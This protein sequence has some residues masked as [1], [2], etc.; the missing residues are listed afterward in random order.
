MPYVSRLDRDRARDLR[1]NQTRAER[2]L[3]QILRHPDLAGR[4]FRRQHPISPYI[5]DF[6]SIRA[7]LIIEADGTQHGPEN[8]YDQKRDAFLRKRGWRILR[9]WNEE[10]LTN[11]D[12]VLAQIQLSLDPHLTSPTSCGR[13]TTD[14]RYESDVG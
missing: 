7:R 14:E 12:Y 2:A 11:P 9:F 13:D 5:A 6:A 4:H 10:I 3:W 8:R 1:R